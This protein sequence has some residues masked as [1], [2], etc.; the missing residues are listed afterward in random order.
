MVF[1]KKS[2]EQIH[3][4]ILKAIDHAGRQKSDIVIFPE[5][6]LPRKYLNSYME[7][8]SSYNLVLIGGVE[9]QP[10]RNK[11]CRNRVL[12]SI[13]C[14]PERNPFGKSYWP[15]Y[16]D[17][18]YPS[19]A[20]FNVL[21]N[22]SFKFVGGNELIIFKNSKWKNFSLLNCADFLSLGLKYELQGRIQTLIV[23]SMNFDSNTFHHL[24]QACIRELYCNCIITNNRSFGS[25]SAYGPY[26]ASHERTIFNIEGQSKPEFHT[27]EINPSEISKVQEESPERLFY[28]EDSKELKKLKDKQ[29]QENPLMKF[30]QLPPDWKKVS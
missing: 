14:N 25:S 12:I 2:I 4:N 23:P 5:M 1:K 26:R 27:I 10:D 9:Y 21:K 3:I 20:E 19:T 22:N 8:A 16:Q 6:S 24:A 18:I 28:P 29:K 13:P 17:K 15:I 30:K 7:K 11:N